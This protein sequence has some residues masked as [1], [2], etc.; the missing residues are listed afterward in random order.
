MCLFLW[1]WQQ[2]PSTVP[3]LPLDWQL[4]SAKVGQAKSPTKSATG[5]NGVNGANGVAPSDFGKD[6]LGKG[7]DRLGF[8]EC[9]DIGNGRESDQIKCCG[10]GSFARDLRSRLFFCIEQRVPSVCYHVN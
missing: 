3:S 2:L 4:N 9:F 6:L 8:R 7:Y 10:V 1:F 5:V